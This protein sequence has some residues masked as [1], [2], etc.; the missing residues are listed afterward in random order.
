MVKN[1]HMLRKLDETLI[2]RERISHVDSL[3]LMDSLWEEA[4]TLGV[5]PLKNP[6]DGIEIDIR[7]ARI[8]NS[9]SK[10]F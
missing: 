5:L 9:C 6:L 4:E 8:L 7:M 3:R 2:A 1:V 10:K